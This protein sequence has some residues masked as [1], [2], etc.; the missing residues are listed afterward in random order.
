MSIFKTQTQLWSL[1]E[2]KKQVDRIITEALAE[3]KPERKRA[4]TV[5]WTF[6]IWKGDEKVPY[7]SYLHFAPNLGYWVVLKD[8]HGNIVLNSPAYCLASTCRMVL[9]EKLYE[10]RGNQYED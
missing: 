6:M 7:R 3:P 4:H 5:I 9:T 8:N 10:L 2:Y 1:E